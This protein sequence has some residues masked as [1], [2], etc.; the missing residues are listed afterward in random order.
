MSE[1]ALIYREQRGL[2]DQDEQMGLLVQRV[3]GAF[4][5]DLFMPQAAGV[6]FSFNPY[7][8]D[9]S[10]DPQAGVLRLVLGLGTRAVDR[11]DDEYV[12]IRALN[13]P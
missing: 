9:E 11:H 1:E 10:I 12:R 2:L 3:S 7:V 5:D 4:Y 13:A 8:W 6:G